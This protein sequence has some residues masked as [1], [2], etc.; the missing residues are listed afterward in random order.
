M[1]LMPDLSAVL[2]PFSRYPK[3]L[4]RQEHTA[5]GTV[6]FLTLRRVLGGL[7]HVEQ[8][9]EPVVHVQLLMAVEQ[10]QP[11]LSGREIGIDAVLTYF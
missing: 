5:A 3:M 8:H 7:H 6:N 11:I 1:V 10:R 2:P 4:K 9:F